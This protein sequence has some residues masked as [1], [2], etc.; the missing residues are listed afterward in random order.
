M[1][2]APG[3]GKSAMDKLLARSIHG[4]VIDHDNIKFTLLEDIISFNGSAKVT[5]RLDWALAESMIEQEWSVIID[6]HCNYK[7][8]LDQGTALAQQYTVVCRV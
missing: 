3:S 7:E 6:G 2:G 1:S 4:V 5:Y 8:I